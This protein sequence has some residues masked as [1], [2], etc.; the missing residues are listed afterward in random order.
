VDEKPVETRVLTPDEKFPDVKAL[1]EAAPQDEWRK[2]P[3]GKPVGPWQKQHLVYLLDLKTMDL[4]T[5]ASG[6]TGGAIC[7]RDLRDKVKWGRKINGPDCFPVVT[8]TDTYMKT[9][10]GGRQRPALKV[11]RFIT[12]NGNG[13]AVEG[14]AGPQI[15][16][17]KAPALSE[18]AGRAS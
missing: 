5:W 2:G 18:E 16:E 15:A 4:F 10:H 1:N 12:L 7:I 3:D 17:V 13:G 6:T 14:P 8:L 11:K 9:K